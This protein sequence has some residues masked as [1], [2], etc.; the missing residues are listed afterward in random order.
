MNRFCMQGKVRLVC[1]SCHYPAPGV[2][3]WASSVLIPQSPVINLRLV[4]SIPFH[5][6]EQN[7]SYTI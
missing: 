7:T 2:H 6:T 3:R 4:C 5:P 1:G